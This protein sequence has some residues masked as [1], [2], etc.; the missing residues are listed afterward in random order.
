MRQRLRAIIFGGAIAFAALGSPAP[1]PAAQQPQAGSQIEFGVDMARRGLWNEALF[2]FERA[3]AERPSDARILN[4][5]AV[6][7]EALGLFE[8]ALE[9]YR[10]GIEAGAANREL[11]SNYSRFLEFY[12]SF[13]PAEEEPATATEEPSRD[14]TGEEARDG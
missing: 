8:E 14:G 2:R 7:Y 11:R 12:Q 6:S 1:A 9:A 10:K 4:N 13:K 3:L 5:I